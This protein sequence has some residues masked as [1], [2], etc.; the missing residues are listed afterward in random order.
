MKGS[1]P[2]YVEAIR[3]ALKFFPEAKGF[4]SLATGLH[5]DAFLGAMKTAKLGEDYSCDPLHNG[6]VIDSL[7][8]KGGLEGNEEEIYA[9][10]LK[11]A[12]LQPQGRAVVIPDAIGYSDQSI[13]NCRPFIC[14]SRTVS[15][16]LQEISCFAT[17]RNSIFIFE[18][19][20]ALLIDHDD[21]VYWAQSF[22]RQ[23]SE[24]SEG[25]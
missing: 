7:A 4:V 22:I 24:D 3:L 12:N 14:H 11:Q 18:S 21:R 23:W 8:S 6:S 19:G 1:D 13:E 17:G 15:K 9:R 2:E 16:R 5:W 20:A 25:N 10:L